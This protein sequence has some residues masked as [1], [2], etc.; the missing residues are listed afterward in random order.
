MSKHIKLSEHGPSSTNEPSLS[1]W[2]SVEDLSNYSSGERSS[3]V[4]LGENVSIA[5]FEKDKTWKYG[6]NSNVFVFGGTG[7]GK[8]R[9]FIE[10]NLAQHLNCNYVVADPKGELLR[11]MGQG[12][13]DDGYKVVVIDTIDPSRSTGFDPLRYIRSEEDI[14]TISK[15][16]FDAVSP[17]RELSQE[18]YWQQAGEMCLR[19]LIGILWDLEHIDGCFA[20]Y[21]KQAGKRK[22]LRMNRLF[23]IAGLIRGGG[24]GRTGELNWGSRP[25][26]FLVDAIENGT[27]FA[28]EF[29][30]VKNGYG[31]RQ[32]RGIRQ[33]A[34]ETLMCVINTLETLLSALDSAEL[35]QMYDREDFCL[36]DI[37]NGKH[38][39]DVKI[40]DN[41]SSRMFLATIFFKLLFREVQKKADASK[42]GRLARRLMFVLDEFPNI[43][44]I[45]DFERSISTVRSRG[46]SFLMCAQSLSQLDSVYG[47]DNAKTILDNCD[48]I[49]Y[50]GGGSSMETARYISA[51]CGDIS[52]NETDSLNLTR[53]VATITASEVTLLP[54]SECI[55]KISGA[56]PL[57]TRK[58]DVL[59]HP[60]AN[61]F[62]AI[63]GITN[64][65]EEV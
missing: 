54:R 17:N 58:V 45:E 61:R 42:E 59:S 55:V 38:F 60:N 3:D 32:Y 12:F 19:S 2:S 8:T 49:V 27:T 16:M 14:R 35:R 9:S 53:R 44:R 31:A 50:M 41:D 65:G 43:G 62:L 24:S 11:T 40:S 25:L 22:Y 37:D 18:Q 26:D 63:S 4:L 10:P 30:A 29:D 20:P 5:F 33:N 46:I 15:L 7:S 28:G 39:I 34:A 48:S 1:G 36:G 52:P 21:A 6:V 13:Q 23:D 64:Y 57:K 56:R 51:L 47:P